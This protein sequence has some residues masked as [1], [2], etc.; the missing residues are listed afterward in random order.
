MSG[1]LLGSIVLDAGALIEVERGGRRVLALVDEGLRAGSAIVLP[2]P[3]LAQVWRGGE[4]Q[5]GLAR[6]RR[7]PQVVVLPFTATDAESVGALLATTGESDVVDAHVVVVSRRTRPAVVL[8]SDPA[9]LS[10]LDPR[11]RLVVV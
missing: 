1:A 10:A 11:I 6:F 5:S 8:T 2:A 4:R 9:D 3:V 7:L